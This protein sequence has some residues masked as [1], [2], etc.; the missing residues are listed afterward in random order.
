[1]A[2]AD[3]IAVHMAKL[4]INAE[5]TCVSDQ[6]G[7]GPSIAEAIPAEIAFRH[8]GPLK[9]WALDGRGRRVR[10]LTT[11]FDDGFV[12]LNTDGAVASMWVEL[13]PR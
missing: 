2:D 1:M 12:G 10:L 8:S 11:T 6:R 4:G 3:H 9:A 5:R 13:A 7:T